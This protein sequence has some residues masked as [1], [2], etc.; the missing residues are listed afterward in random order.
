MTFRPAISA[1]ALALAASL[2]AA[3]PAKAQDVTLT[4]T[5]FEFDDFFESCYPQW[6]VVVSPAGAVEEVSLQTVT[7]FGAPGN[8]FRRPETL[9]TRTC[10]EDLTPGGGTGF[11]CSSSGDDDQPC[12]MVVSVSVGEFT[13]DGEACG[14]VSVTEH[15]KL[16]AE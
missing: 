12:E 4:L 3:A 14:A 11:S 7:T 5:G 1:A 15:D 13:C 8:I 2:A 9:G 16:I 10:T 6:A